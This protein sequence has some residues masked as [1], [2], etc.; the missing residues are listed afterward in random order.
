LMH[1]YDGQG[2]I[3]ASNVFID[4]E[5]F[6]RAC[7][8]YESAVFL[9]LRDLGRRG[10]VRILLTDITLKEIKA[11]VHSLVAKAEPP[12]AE[13]I[14]K[15]SSRPEVKALFEPYAAE[16]IEQEFIAQLEAFLKDGQVTVLSVQD[17][18]LKPVLELYFR[19]Q[20]PFGAGK[21]KSEFPDAL[22][23][24]TLVE[25]TNETGLDL[26]VVSGDSDFAS[27]CADRE[28]LHHFETLLKYLDAVASEDEVL[29]DFIR[30]EVFGRTEAEAKGK[31]EN[32]FP[33]IDF[34]LADQDGDVE[35][36]Q[37]IDVEYEGDVEIVSLTATTAVVELPAQV[38]FS[39]D[40]RYL[41]PGTG[42][43]DREDDETY[44]Q[45]RIAKTV[46]RTAVINLTLEV[47]FVDLDP[48][49]LHVLSVSVEGNRYVEVDS[50]YN[51]G[52][53]DH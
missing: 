20:P 6:R 8:N 35:Y 39:A 24:E 31:L 45:D 25:W 34:V 47:G 29:S 36:A 52:W 9:A 15:N 51:D 10:R 30:E 4:T 16:A 11:L 1:D 28:L 14:L 12:K 18:C 37:L 46:E 38:R 49:S 17:R 2:V 23:I 13:P 40:V 32:V 33:D 22:V 48:K 50:G 43:Y 7:F 44:F 3:K 26:A 19:G 42:T 27:G 53:D 21:K 41:D 5:V